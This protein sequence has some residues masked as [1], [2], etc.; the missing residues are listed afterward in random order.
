MKRTKTYERT[1]RLLAGLLC[2]CMIVSMLGSAGMLPVVRLSAAEDFKDLSK[3][4]TI[5]LEVYDSEGE[6]KI[7][8]DKDGTYHLEEGLNYTFKL[9]F[10]AKGA[11]ENNSEYTYTLPE[12][13]RP[14]E[15]FT[16]KI[17]MSDGTTVGKM[18][19]D[20]DGSVKV[21]FNED[22]ESYK[23]LFFTYSVSKTV[24]SDLQDFG[25][26]DFKITVTDPDP[27]S[28]DRFAEKSESLPSLN[29]QTELDYIPDELRDAWKDF[30][31]NAAIRSSGLWVLV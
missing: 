26:E 23:D 22:V 4:F 12:A 10:T 11:I 16:L 27:D 2:L 20:T 9:K 21:T 17:K 7:E 8:K 5:T 31:K 6:E 29:I 19:V 3:D 30:P 25:F 28:V 14:D 18:T 24:T 1:H 13:L 15:P